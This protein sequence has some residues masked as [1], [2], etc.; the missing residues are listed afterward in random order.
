MRLSLCARA[1]PCGG[2]RQHNTRASTA[3]GDSPRSNE[4]SPSIYYTKL[5]C[6]L[7]VGS[8]AEAV[9]VYHGRRFEPACSPIH[10]SEYVEKR[11]S[12]VGQVEDGVVEHLSIRRKTHRWRALTVHVPGTDKQSRKGCGGSRCETAGEGTTPQRQS[13]AS[14]HW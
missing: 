7:G 5:A 10:V 1:Q 12:R 2:L 9:N 8:P 13:N 14:K 4:R 3:V 6:L 11:Q